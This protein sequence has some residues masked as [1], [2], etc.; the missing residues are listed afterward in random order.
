MQRT[1]SVV[2]LDLAVVSTPSPTRAR[3]LSLRALLSRAPPQAAL[4]V[5]ANPVLELRQVRERSALGSM[6]MSLAVLYE[7]YASQGKYVRDLTHTGAI[8]TEFHKTFVA[9][10]KG[11]T[12]FIYLF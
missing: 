5:A 9:P 7:I 12:L 6:P 4:V 10:E 11:L 3:R 2:A 1:S 8:A